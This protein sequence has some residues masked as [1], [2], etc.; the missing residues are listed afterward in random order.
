MT[1]LTFSLQ[2]SSPDTILKVSLPNK[3]GNI[4]A[5]FVSTAFSDSMEENGGGVLKSI[6]E[7]ARVTFNLLLIYFWMQMKF[8]GYISQIQ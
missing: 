7:Q 6:Q 4:T 5:A 2:Y 3:M 8:A 1:S